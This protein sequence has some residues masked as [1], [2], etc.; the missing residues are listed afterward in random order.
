MVVSN[1]RFQFLFA[2]VIAVSVTIYWNWQVTGEGLA[3][4]CT[5]NATKN[6]ATVSKA[7][8][9][10]TLPDF[11]LGVSTGHAG[12]TSSHI[13]AKKASCPWGKMEIPFESTHPPRGTLPH[14]NYPCMPIAHYVPEME[15]KRYEM[16]DGTYVDMGHFYNEFPN[17][18]ECLAELLGSRLAMV[19]IRRNRYSIA[20]SFTNRQPFMT[21]CLNSSRGSPHP[22]VSYCPRSDQTH[23]PTALRVP[24][25]NVWDNLS[26]FQQFLWLADELEL[27]YQTVKEKYPRTNY[28]EINWTT[29]T[30][31]A[32]AMAWLWREH[33]NCHSEELGKS[34]VTNSK[35]HIRHEAG[36]R[37]CSWEILQDLEYRKLIQMEE[38]QE[39]RILGPYTQRVGGQECME[40]P[41]EL[42]DLLNKQGQ[43]IQNW[44]VME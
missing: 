28:Y 1:H 10:E 35:K 14:P 26:P 3:M 31:F 23:G 42:E 11:I 29:A 8:Y 5:T 33:F 13:I 6:S 32:E 17:G 39:Q 44:V 24:S 16:T 25:D 43:N 20:L 7:Y 12:S 38:E 27:R 36:G 40:S 4:E 9:L 30:D 22:T 18:M 37:N 15:K 19:R 2:A 21:P 34:S 41:K